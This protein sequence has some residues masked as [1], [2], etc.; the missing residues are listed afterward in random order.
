MP[1]SFERLRGT[2]NARMKVR[3]HDPLVVV[4]GEDTSLLAVI[5]HSRGPGVRAWTVERSVHDHDQQGVR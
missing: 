5:E 3:G 2:H 1:L 4:T